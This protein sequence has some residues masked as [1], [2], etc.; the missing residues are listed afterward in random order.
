MCEKSCTS[1]PAL[2]YFVLFFYNKTHA[3]WYGKQLLYRYPVA[4]YLAGS[5][6]NNI[7]G[8]GKQRR[9][10]MAQNVLA[11]VAGHQITEEE[12]QAFI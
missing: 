6:T 12:L 4:K 2:A 9:K 5:D 3:T 1:W 7:S 11:V 8:S 10:F